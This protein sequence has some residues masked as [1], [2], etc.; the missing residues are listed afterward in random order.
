MMY[1]G[2]TVEL[3]RRDAGRERIAVEFR[4]LSQ[5]HHQSIFYDIKFSRRQLSGYDARLLLGRGEAS[6]K[7]GQSTS[8]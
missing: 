2:I 6:H 5:A 7:F 1:R 8:I 4:R 3:K